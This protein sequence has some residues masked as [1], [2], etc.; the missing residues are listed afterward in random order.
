MQLFEAPR[1][2]PSFL[3]LFPY[4]PPKKGKIDVL[5][6]DAQYFVLRRRHVLRY[7]EKK[8]VVPRVHLYS[9]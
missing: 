7:Y 8:S 2:N 4:K 5:K 6:K 3:Q 9:R 1:P